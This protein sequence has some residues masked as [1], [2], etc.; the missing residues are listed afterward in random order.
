MSK[1][2]SGINLHT[3][4]HTTQDH[5]LAKSTRPTRGVPASGRRQQLAVKA[6][7]SIGEDTPFNWVCVDL[8]NFALQGQDDNAP[9][10]LP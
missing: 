7:E 1:R 3:P 9:T 5:H 4:L 6:A 8:Q 10:L 2:V